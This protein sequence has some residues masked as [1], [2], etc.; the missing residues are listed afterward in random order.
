MNSQ[1]HATEQ[2]LFFTLVQ[3]TI[4]VL[5]ARAGG[6]LFRRF[7][8]SVAV[9]EIVTGILL[10]PSMF[11]TLAPG[12]FDW[13]FRSAPPQPML[14]LSQIGLLLLMFQIGLEFDFGHLQFR[15]L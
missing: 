7:G 9:G 10:G 2:L 14:I 6:A 15:W 11:G 4:I 13:V 3:L 5:A 8:Q 12:V 1:V